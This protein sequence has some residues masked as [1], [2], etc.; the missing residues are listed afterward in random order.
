M[1][2]VH[3]IATLRPAPGK[4]A[5]LR[6]ILCET[7]RNVEQVEP[8]CLTFL[9]TECHRPDGAVEF[10]VVERW[11]SQEA[12]EQHQQRAWLRTMYATFDEKHLLERPEEIEMLALIS[13]FAAR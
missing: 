2:G 12:L 4:A 3:L 9:V 6:Q 10:K 7:A 11:A 8:S 1:T 13:G 5:E